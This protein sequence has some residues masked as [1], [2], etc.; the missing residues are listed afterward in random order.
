MGC[1]VV[2]ILEEK[3]TSWTL[4]YMHF[5][6]KKQKNL[7]YLNKTAKTQLKGKINIYN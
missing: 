2:A 7:A 5:D 3:Y 6:K 1:L 4:F